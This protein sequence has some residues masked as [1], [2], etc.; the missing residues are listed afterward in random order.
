MKDPCSCKCYCHLIWQSLVALTTITISSF[1]ED[2][3][4]GSIQAICG[5]LGWG[6]K[7]WERGG[8]EEA[9]FLYHV[10]P[11][12]RWDTIIPPGIGN[13]SRAPITFGRRHTTSCELHLSMRESFS[14]EKSSRQEQEIVRNSRT[15]SNQQCSWVLKHDLELTW[16]VNN[17]RTV[18]YM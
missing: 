2:L 6:R 7:I 12:S 14:R 17:G 5:D 11:R 4:E 3:L 18:S 8:E 16:Q 13:G 15:V 9:I 10:G 1:H